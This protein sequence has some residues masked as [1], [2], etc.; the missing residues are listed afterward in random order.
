MQCG[1]YQVASQCAFDRDLRR[2]S[3][4]DFTDQNDIGIM[5]QDV[6]QRLRKAKVDGGINLD[7]HD[8][9]EPVFDRIFDRQDVILAGV[10]LLQCCIQRRRLA[11]PRRSG[12]EHQPLVAIDQRPEPALVGCGEADVGKPAQAY[13]GIENADDNILPVHCGHHRDAHVDRSLRRIY[14]NRA[15][16][17][18]ATLRHIHGREN[19]DPGRNGWQK[20][21][22]ELPDRHQGAV[23][24]VSHI[25][26]AFAR[27][28]VDIRRAP[29]YGIEQQIIYQ[30]YDRLLLRKPLDR[31]HR[32]LTVFL[33]QPLCLAI[34]RGV[35]DEG[36]MRRDGGSEVRRASEYDLDWLLCP[37][38]HRRDLVAIRWIVGRNHQLPRV[39][40]QRQYV[41][42]TCK[43]GRYTGERSCFD[44]EFAQ[45]YVGHAELLGQ[46]TVELVFIDLASRDQQTAESRGGAISLRGERA[47][48]TRVIHEARGG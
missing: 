46:R 8:A 3:V 39:E 42:R 14:V 35:L 24:S 11:G 29:L 9:V 44:I 32:R 10:Q 20:R 5:T 33:E 4:T 31:R 22:I 38:S 17:R 23:N 25:G 12:D 26:A 41:A 15:I 18:Q 1:Q 27:M 30:A 48:Y 37:E 34:Q 36:V 2:V 40:H 13:L 21:P 16:L 47:M 19:F 6:S 7:L 28:Q 43:V 45:A